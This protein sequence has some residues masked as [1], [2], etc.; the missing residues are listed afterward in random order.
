MSNPIYSGSDSAGF[1]IAIKSTDDLELYNLACELQNIELRVLT[2]LNDYLELTARSCPK[3][4]HQH[5]GKR[6]AYICIG[7]PC[8]YRPGLVGQGRE[9][10]KDKVQS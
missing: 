6:L 3:C 4:G 9:G 2:Q 7:C 1:W 5:T 10:W 8:D